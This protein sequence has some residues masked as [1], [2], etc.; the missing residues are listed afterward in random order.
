M[1]VIRKEVMK[2]QRV[3]ICFPA[4]YCTSSVSLDFLTSILFCHH[5]YHA[6]DVIPGTV[7]NYKVA[8]VQSS[9]E[10]SKN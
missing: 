3:I 8:V 4:V 7:A 6:D 2:E 1:D 5:P 9:G 10:G